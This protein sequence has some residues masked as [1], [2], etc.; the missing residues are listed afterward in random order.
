MNAPQRCHSRASSLH[1]SPWNLIPFVLSTLGSHRITSARPHPRAPHRAHPPAHQT[2]HTAFKTTNAIQ[3][4]KCSKTSHAPPPSDY[5]CRKTPVVAGSRPPSH[6]TAPSPSAL[7][8]FGDFNAKSFGTTF[9]KPCG[10][11]MGTSADTDKL[12]GNPSESHLRAELLQASGAGVNPILNCGGLV[13]R[14]V[15]RRSARIWSK[16]A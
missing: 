12:G 15:E 1:R 13:V 7:H 14:A 11:Q 10:K 6:R 16:K 3:T 5:Q 4:R 8:N 9:G 2:N